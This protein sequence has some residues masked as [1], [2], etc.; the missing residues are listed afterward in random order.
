VA[1]PS[2]ALDF[3]SLAS[4]RRLCACAGGN[5]LVRGCSAAG[6]SATAGGRTGPEAVVWLASVVVWED[7]VLLAGDDGPDAGVEDEEPEEPQAARTSAAA[8]AIPASRRRVRMDVMDVISS[9]RINP[10]DVVV[11]GSAKVVGW[12]AGGRRS[13]GGRGPN[14]GEGQHPEICSARLPGR[15][16]LHGSERTVAQSCGR[17]PAVNVWLSP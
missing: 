13:P 12:W 17:R 5:W 10:R 15:A 2:S 9:P 16:D 4:W 11:Q 7:C 3:A 6:S 14:S 1:A 8:A